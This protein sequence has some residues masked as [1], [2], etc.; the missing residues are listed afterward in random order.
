MQSVE[1]TINELNTLNINFVTEP[2]GFIYILDFLCLKSGIK[3]TAN[4]IDVH[5]NTLQN[6]RQSKSQPPYSEVIRITKLLGYDI[7]LTRSTYIS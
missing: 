5:Y 6:W 7:V 1:E 3:P 2:N 4:Y